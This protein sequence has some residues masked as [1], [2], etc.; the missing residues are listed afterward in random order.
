MD[1]QLNAS[2]DAPGAPARP[3]RDREATTRRILEAA[4]LLFAEHGY[5]HVTMRMIANAA[6][7]NVALV[8]RYFGSKAGLFAEVLASRSPLESVIEGDMGGLPARLAAHV[9][10]RLSAE[11]A[12]PVARAIDRAGNS[13]EIRMILRQRVESAILGRLTEKLE[14]P[15]A[16]ERATLATAI[17]LGGGSLRRTF[18]QEAAKD[19]DLGSMERRL[20]AMFT[21]C[22]TP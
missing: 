15:R 7:A 5:D 13:P 9:A 14:G 19:L 1:T 20:T 22:L 11:A 6:E 17:I 4:T 21:A 3:W 12:A 8:N 2:P 10:R 18:G 16:R